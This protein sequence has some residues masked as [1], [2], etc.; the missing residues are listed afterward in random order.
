MV[1]P[2]GTNLWMYGICKSIVKLANVNTNGRGGG[3]RVGLYVW[4]CDVSVE[5]GLATITEIHNAMQMKQ[6]Q[7]QTQ[8][9][10]QA[11]T[12][13]VTRAIIYI[14]E[15]PSKYSQLEWQALLNATRDTSIQFLATTTN[16]EL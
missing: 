6:A 10:K 9:Q 12:S 13:Q 5:Q 3:G 4:K 14:P 15:G 7:K 8:V 2:R 16:L 1:G 11:Q